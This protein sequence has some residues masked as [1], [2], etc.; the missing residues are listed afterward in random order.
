MCAHPCSDLC[1]YGPI[2]SELS[3]KFDAFMLNMLMR[4][5]R[6]EKGS[7]CLFVREV[8]VKNK[9]RFN[10]SYRREELLSVIAVGLFSIAAAIF[11][12]EF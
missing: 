7:P 9:Y 10:T 8:S 6:Q 5:M 12:D 4:C 3:M 1:R 11:D 2:C